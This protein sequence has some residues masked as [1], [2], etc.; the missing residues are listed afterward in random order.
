MSK[1]GKKSIS[2]PAG[3]TVALEQ[4]KLSAKG[5]KGELFMLVHKDAKVEI[6]D[7]QIVVSKA[8]EVP[9][10]NAIWGLTRS[11]VNNIIIGVSV[12]YEKKLEL[13][14]VGFR[15]SI[16][17][18]KIVMALG[19]SHP[20]EMEIVEGITAKLEENNT[21]SISGIDKQLVGQFAANVK[22]LKK[23]EPYKGKGFRYAGEKVRRKAG[24][25]AASTK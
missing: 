1:I 5:P 9:G 4:D 24:K 16:Q 25:K 12:G 15:M 8:A 19:F 7:N 23:V 14:G 22:N 20:V 10:A 11:L 18:K 3:V 6:K 2:I 21:L 17:G 13:Q